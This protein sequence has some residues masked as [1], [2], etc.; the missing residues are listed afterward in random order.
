[1]TAF[2]LFHCTTGRKA[3]VLRFHTVEAAKAHAVGMFGEFIGCDEDEAGNIDIFTNRGEIL[4][5]E[6]VTE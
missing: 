6:P 1:M 4:A 3:A 2:D 5:I